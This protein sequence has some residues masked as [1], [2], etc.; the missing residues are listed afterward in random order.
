M[1]EFTFEAIE[2]TES[3]VELIFGRIEGEIV[4]AGIVNLVATEGFFILGKTIPRVIGIGGW[5]H[6]P[7]VENGFARLLGIENHLN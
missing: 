4:S 1:G 2:L 5:S 6:T 7:E 3:F